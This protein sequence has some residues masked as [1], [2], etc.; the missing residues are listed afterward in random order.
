M[1]VL[2]F[3]ISLVAAPI[4]SRPGSTKAVAILKACV[5]T[6]SEKRL[7]PQQSLKVRV[8]LLRDSWP[9][10][11]QSKRI[12]MFFGPGHASQY[13]VEG[14][15]GLPGERRLVLTH[16]MWGEECVLA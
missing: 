2:C 16:L 10:R 4:N 11:L 6:F 9:H 15:E 3:S 13:R 14:K 12:C 7:R 5:C 8:Q 1:F